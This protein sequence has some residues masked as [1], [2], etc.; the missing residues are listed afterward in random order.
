MKENKLRFSTLK[1]TVI[2]GWAC[3]PAMIRAFQDDYGV[4]V[5]HAWGMTEMSP[6]GTAGTFKGKHLK[7]SKETRDAWQGKQGRSI[8]GVD[9][10]IV[11]EDGK[12]RPGMARRSATCRRPAQVLRGQDRQVVDARRRGIRPQATASRH[13]QALQAHLAAAD[14]GFP[15]A[16]KKRVI[17]SSLE[18][19]VADIELARLDKKNAFTGEMYA[20]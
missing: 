15:P 17:R 2:G 16:G 19:R 12:D 10:R 4:Q 9:M 8:Y 7:M 13:R 11:G 6:L 5:L 1:R 18:G 14:E 3:P 20:A